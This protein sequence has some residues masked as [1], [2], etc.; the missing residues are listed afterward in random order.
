MTPEEV[1]KV[2]IELLWE[3]IEE[4]QDYRREEGCD[5]DETVL[6]YNDVETSLYEKMEE[7]DPEKNYSSS[8]NKSQ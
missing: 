4:F 1:K 5:I 7:I 8:E 6:T 2:K 3:L